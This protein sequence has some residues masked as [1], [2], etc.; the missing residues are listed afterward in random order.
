MVGNETEFSPHGSRDTPV[1]CLRPRGIAW[2]WLVWCLPSIGQDQATPPLPAASPQTALVGRT[3]TLHHIPLLRCSFL[4]ISIDG[5]I[6]VKKQNLRRCHSDATFAEDL[7]AATT[8]GDESVYSTNSRN[9]PCNP[10][11][12]NCLSHHMHY[13][14][15]TLDSWLIDRTIDNKPLDR[16]SKMQC[17]R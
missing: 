17:L 2:Q 12:L 3:G 14:V 6:Q 5:K 7:V 15:R 4:K 1:S 10:V 9:R 16:S 11:T 13:R 8:E